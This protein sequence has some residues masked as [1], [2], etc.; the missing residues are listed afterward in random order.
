M[1]SRP[2]I[3]LRFV[4]KLRIF[5]SIKI[6]S[7]K[8]FITQRIGDQ[9]KRV[10]HVEFFYW[11]HQTKC[12]KPPDNYVKFAAFSINICRAR[13]SKTE[14]P[15]V[16]LIPEY[17]GTARWIPSLFTSPRHYQTCWLCTKKCPCYPRGTSSTTV[18]P[19]LSR[20]DQMNIFHGIALARKEFD[21]L[22]RSR[23]YRAAV[24]HGGSAGMIWMPSYTV[25]ISFA[26]LCISFHGQTGGVLAV[27]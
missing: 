23:N 24:I 18:T 6:R 22:L 14:L 13:T 1:F 21:V 20:N 16:M 4:Q 26:Y 10:E 5:F 17:S 3:C 11:F 9:N 27:R 8:T 25:K 7:T 19:T 12:L 15:L 2:N